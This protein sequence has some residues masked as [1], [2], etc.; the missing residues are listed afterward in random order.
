MRGLE[1]VLGEILHLRIVVFR[2]VPLIIFLAA[3]HT[4]SA[5]NINEPTKGWGSSKHSY[6]AGEVKEVPAGFPKFMDN[7][8][9]SEDIAD[10]QRRK[11]AWI[12]ANPE[13]YKKIVD[14]S[15][16][17]QVKQIPQEEFDRMPQDKKDFILGKPQE[18]K[19]VG[20]TSDK[21]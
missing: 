3:I 1:N 11:E 9:P 16:S 4:V 18:Y 14:D 20:N 2:V 8:N 17:I 7:G 10:Y 12:K 6:Q 5:Q 19:V 21:Q 15:K 13:A